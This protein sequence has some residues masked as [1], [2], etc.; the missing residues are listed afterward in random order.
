MCATVMP[1]TPREI[2]CL[3]RRRWNGSYNEDRIT[4]TPA[5]SPT[6][7]MMWNLP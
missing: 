3:S 5:V 6:A 1:S 4:Q 2:D 7:A